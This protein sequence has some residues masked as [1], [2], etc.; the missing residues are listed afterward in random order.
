M[1]YLIQH[2]YNPENILIFGIDMIT[3]DDTIIQL[4]PAIAYWNTKRIIYL[5]QFDQILDKYEGD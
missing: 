4:I 2:L 3:P 5:L 1:Y